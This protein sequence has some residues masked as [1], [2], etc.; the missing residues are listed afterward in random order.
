MN[1][2]EDPLWQALPPASKKGISLEAGPNL[3]L[4]RTPQRVL[5]GQFYVPQNQSKPPKQHPLGGAG[6]RGFHGW[7]FAQP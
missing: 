2:N 1:L 4:T 6:R 5:F 3:L 7:V